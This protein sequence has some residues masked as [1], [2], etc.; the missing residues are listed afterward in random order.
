MNFDDIIRILC[1]GVCMC[2]YVVCSVRVNVWGKIRVMF[3]PLLVW[4][5]PAAIADRRLSALLY[6]LLS[7]LSDLRISSHPLKLQTID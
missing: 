7:I 3:S 6:Q 4:R 2:V 5:L 1:I